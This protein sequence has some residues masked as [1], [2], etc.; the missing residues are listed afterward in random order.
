VLALK[1]KDLDEQL[2]NTLLDSQELS[3]KIRDSEFSLRTIT[4]DLSRVSQIGDTAAELTDKNA[5]L[6]L[7]LEVLRRDIE[8]T[9][10]LYKKIYASTGILV[11][12]LQSVVSYID[13]RLS[14]YTTLLLDKSFRMSLTRGKLVLESD[15]GSYNALSNG[16]KRRLDISIQFALHDYIYMNCGIGFDT[17]FIDEILDTLDTVGVSNIIEVLEL[18][19]SYCSLGRVFIVTHNTDLKTYFDEVLLV[20]KDSEGFSTIS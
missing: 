1:S 3:Q 10:Y 6:T 18:K 7:Q 4:S 20:S 14:T 11:D 5:Q 2:R 16:E 9:D 8:S 13:Q 19:R 12:I 17:L 15:S